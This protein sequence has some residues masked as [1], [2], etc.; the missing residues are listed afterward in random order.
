MS[1]SLSYSENPIHISRGNIHTRMQSSPLEPGE[2]FLNYQK[3]VLKPASKKRVSNPYE[4]W[5]GTLNPK[6]PIRLGAGGFLS[7][8]GNFSEFFETLEYS[9]SKK[10]YTKKAVL[11][12]E[13]TYSSLRVGNVYYI[14]DNLYIEETDR[15]P[16]FQGGDLAVYFGDGRWWNTSNSQYIDEIEYHAI[17][18][19]NFNANVDHDNSKINNAKDAL[20]DLYA[21][22]ADLDKFGKIYYSELPDDIR[23]L[24]NGKFSPQYGS[25]EVRR[26]ISGK[27]TFA[28]NPS[29][30]NG[31]DDLHDTK[32]HTVDVFG[33]LNIK[34]FSTINVF[35]P[36]HVKGKRQSAF[37]VNG[38]M[39]GFPYNTE[40]PGFSSQ[41]KKFGN[42]DISADL[43]THGSTNID[44]SLIVKENADVFSDVSIGKNLYVNENIYSHGFLQKY[45]SQI[46]LSSYDSDK[47]FFVSFDIPNNTVADIE[48][49]TKNT[50]ADYARLYFTVSSN[51][52][53]ADPTVIVFDNTQLSLTFS[54]IKIEMNKIYVSIKGGQIYNTA[55]N[56]KFNITDTAEDH[57]KLKRLDSDKIEYY[58]DVNPP[59]LP[60]NYSWTY[61]DTNDYYVETKQVYYVRWLNNYSVEN[62]LN[63]AHLDEVE[64]YDTLPKLWNHEYWEYNEEDGIYYEKRDP[65]VKV[66]WLYG[67]VEIHY[68]L[69]YFPEQRKDGTFWRKEG[70]I[71]W[72]TEKEIKLTV[73]YKL[74]KTMQV[75]KD[76]DVIEEKFSQF[77]HANIALP[78]PHSIDNRSLIGFILDG[79]VFQIPKQMQQFYSA[80]PENMIM[81]LK[82]ELISQLDNYSGDNPFEK[83]VAAIY[84]NN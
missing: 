24:A 12:N 22:K 61:D 78:I 31:I 38:K 45:Y 56:T 63:E 47:Y 68:D 23:F 55:L 72:Q 53:M 66:V 26:N 3:N 40:V 43:S 62:T 80:T 65:N 75:F 34:D 18:R 19:S 16:G 7:L 42:V 48:I 51:H 4:L 13:S 30:K 59:E 79:Q 28:V 81:F 21:T 49:Y 27:D 8:A 33:D 60:T 39:F 20:D 69:D 2:L 29:N 58:H 77:H 14:D 25:F 36:N 76:N 9:D 35:G 64:Q 32:A 46:D 83:E 71:I 67:G 57:I 17:K 73:V 1:N 41:G 15:N 70:D 44:K 6:Q 50:K 11:P 54:N 52:Q 82:T 5:I 84:Y 10:K 74:N 37:G